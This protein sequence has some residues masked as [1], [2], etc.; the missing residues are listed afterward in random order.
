MRLR[1]QEVDC[2]HEASRLSREEYLRH[3]I[4]LPILK[5]LE[6]ALDAVL[7]SDVDGVNY[8]RCPRDFVAGLVDG[9]SPKLAIELPRDFLC[10]EE[11]TNV[12]DKFLSEIFP[13]K[14]SRQP[15]IDLGARV[16]DSSELV[17]CLCS[18]LE[19]IELQVQEEEDNRISSTSG[20]QADDTSEK[21]EATRKS[22]VRGK[23]PH[24]SSGGQ[25]TFGQ[26]VEQQRRLLISEFVFVEPQLELRDC[27]PQLGRFNDIHELRRIDDAC[28]SQLCR[29]RMSNLIAK[30]VPIEVRMIPE[31]LNLQ[32][33]GE[34]EMTYPLKP[35]GLLHWFESHEGTMEKKTHNLPIGG[36]NTKMNLEDSLAS[37]LVYHEQYTQPAMLPPGLLCD[38]CGPQPC[39]V[40]F[41]DSATDP[42]HGIK[43]TFEIPGTC[44]WSLSS[45]ANT[46]PGIIAAHES[47]AL[48]SDLPRLY[49]SQSFESSVVIPELSLDDQEFQFLPVPVVTS[50]QEY[51]I[52]AELGRL[53]SLNCDPCTVPATDWL[54]LDW[55]FFHGLKCT[56][57]ICFNLQAHLI[58]ESQCRQLP[59]SLI[60]EVVT[61]PKGSKFALELRLLEDN[62]FYQDSSTISHVIGATGEKIEALICSPGEISQ[63]RGK[64]SHQSPLKRQKSPCIDLPTGI[65]RIAVNGYASNLPKNHHSSGVADGNVDPESQ[66]R[67]YNIDP[68][69]I[70]TSHL[71]NMQPV[72]R[73]RTS[74]SILNEGEHFQRK[75]QEGKPSNDLE[76]STSVQSASDFR[77]NDTDF[78]V[79]A[80]KGLT[81]SDLQATNDR[82][83]DSSTVVNEPELLTTP[84]PD[85]EDHATESV[86]FCEHEVEISS[87]IRKCMCSLS[88]DY[89]ALLAMEEIAVLQ[90]PGE[91]K[92]LKEFGFD[93][94]GNSYLTSLIS[95]MANEPVSRQR[96]TVLR[97]LIALHVLRHTA[98]NLCNYG[99]QVGHLYLENCFEKMQFLEGHIMSSRTELEEAYDLVEKGLVEDHPKLS[100]LDKL[101]GPA[102]LDI[103]RTTY[104]STRILLLADRRAFFTLVRKLVSLGLAPYQI[105]RKE[106]YLHNGV[107]LEDS[108]DKLKDEILEALTFSDCLLVS[109]GYVNPLFPVQKFTMIIH[110]GDSPYTC[111]AINSWTKGRHVVHFFKVLVHPEDFRV[112]SSNFS[113]QRQSGCQ[114]P[115]GHNLGGSTALSNP[116]ICSA[117]SADQSLS[118]STILNRN[119]QFSEQTT[120]SSSEGATDQTVEENRSSERREMI[121]VANISHPNAHMLT[122]RRSSYQ[123]ILRLERENLQVVE[124]ELRLPVDLILSPESCIVVYT[125]GKLNLEPH[126]LKDRQETLQNEVLTHLKAICFSFRDCIMIFEGPTEFTTEALEISTQLYNLAM[127]LDIQ[128]QCFASRHS[129]VTDKILMHS[130]QG[131][132]R[133]K[134]M[135]S[136]P[137]MT[138]GPT[139]AEVFLTGFPSI[140]PLTAHAILSSGCPLPLFISY[141]PEQQYAAVEPYEVPKH[142]L[143]LF[144]AQCTF[145]ATGT[146]AVSGCK[147][148]EVQTNQTDAGFPYHHQ[149]NAPVVCVDVP[150]EVSR[151]EVWPSFPEFPPASA[152][153]EDSP[154]CDVHD[155]NFNH[156]FPEFF[157]LS[158]ISSQAEDPVETEPSSTEL[159]GVVDIPKHSLA[160]VATWPLNP[161]ERDDVP[162]YEGAL[163]KNNAQE[164]Y[165]QDDIQWFCRG[166][167]SAAF[168]SGRFPS[169]FDNIFQ[170][171]QNPRPTQDEVEDHPFQFEKRHWPWVASAPVNGSK[172]L[173]GAPENLHR[174]YEILQ[175]SQEPI[176]RPHIGMKRGAS[177]MSFILP[178]V[179]GGRQDMGLNNAL[180]SWNDHK[181]VRGVSSEFMT[182]TFDLQDIGDPFA[183]R[184]PTGP[185][186]VDEFPPVRPEWIENSPSVHEE[187]NVN[188]RSRQSRRPQ[189][190]LK[191][192]S[193][194]RFRYQSRSPTPATASNGFTQTTI[195]F[196]TIKI[197][198]TAPRRNRTESPSAASLPPTTAGKP[199]FARKTFNEPVVDRRPRAI[200]GVARRGS[201]TQQRLVWRT[202]PSSSCSKRQKIS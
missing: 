32:N 84:G 107:L 35:T 104:L 197:P 138:E 13:A 62:D 3:A 86:V 25:K 121:I 100:Y 1:Y 75:S 202:N 61:L 151:P 42:L 39:S 72:E 34:N 91:L 89:F 26:H 102:A 169:G 131:V 53:V 168:Q 24:L 129:D 103:H 147:G 77:G 149:A 45:L 139:L 159:S 87:E 66:C 59:T 21:Q 20:S 29:E 76:R 67:K 47:E 137:I 182:E 165:A 128:F 125:M 44:D 153:N 188:Y 81:G 2:F 193:L 190:T 189:A 56:N 38:E 97:G 43:L 132:R 58:E 166:S 6:E 199:T 118:E 154:T 175:D 174:G 122:G 110:Y 85:G 33:Q 152:I 130:I 170:M 167:E 7:E 142:C 16:I 50:P 123:K 124:R 187:T 74:K 31:S 146:T 117:P 69:R 157:P 115:Q 111:A 185:N 106:N 17:H 143:E 23:T 57:S 173:G 186:G 164:M 176:S 113:P 80:R 171:A 96:Q 52:D 68:G 160:E 70:R 94:D 5:S 179:H 162:L 116:K 158:E 183:S 98:L 177:G 48:V 79:R 90:T 114:D 93:A 105:D 65:D 4:P 60:T 161:S 148:V 195:K 22:I 136:Y 156:S 126:N 9:S 181:R 184:L 41:V 135:P 82:Q 144:R 11:T 27:V 155:V 150:N 200:L 201:D 145:K 10:I 180:G 134:H 51:I 119:V 19:Q 49:P 15:S 8:S 14:L 88:S 78:F 196:P 191:I 63:R 140:N 101:L 163:R 127:A 141:T 73:F 109:Y 54:Y 36:F 12:Y 120:R 71:E 83:N 198:R 112:K 178:T 55:H 46:T 40:S 64:P 28:R 194:D 108:L 95:N 37:K 192:S 18:D 172:G 133:S 99:I 30:I 92:T